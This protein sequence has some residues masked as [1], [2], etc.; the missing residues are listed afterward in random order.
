MVRRIGNLKSVLT[1]ARKRNLELQETLDE[2]AVWLSEHKHELDESPASLEELAG[3]E[4]DVESKYKSVFDGSPDITCIHDGSGHI[5]EVNAAACELLGYSREQLFQMSIFDFLPPQS[6]DAVPQYLEQLDLAGVCRFDTTYTT[7]DGM[8]ISVDVTCTRIQWDGSP[9][10]LSSARDI[11][12]IKRQ[13]QLLEQD[14]S[15]LDILLNNSCDIFYFKD[16]QSRFIRVNEVFANRFGAKDPSELLGK[17]DFDLFAD[18]HASQVREDETRIMETGQAINQEEKET[19]PDGRETW[20]SS[21]KSPLYD[22][23]GKICGIFGIS[24][25]ITQRKEA[26]M[27]L[28]SLNECLL[29][30][31]PDPTANI[32]HLVK[33]CGETLRGHRAFYSRI[34]GDALHCADHWNQEQGSTALPITDGYICHD[35]FVQNRDEVLV[36]RNLQETPYA[37]SDPRVAADGLAT[38]IGR[39]VKRSGKPIGVVCVVFQR[40]VAPSEVDSNLID[41]AALA[42]G[43]EEDRRSAQV[44]LEKAR[45]EAIAA[46]QAK[47]EFLA[48]MSHEI[49]TPMNG[50]I[51]MAELALDT[52]L[53]AE[54]R[55]YLEM[56]RLSADSLLCI[57]NDILDFSKIEAKKLEIEDLDFEL[58]DSIYDMLSTLALRAHQKDLELACHVFSDVPDAVVGDARR[59]RQIIVNLVGNAIKFTESG[60]VVVSV[61]LESQT[62][63]GVG[64]HFS[65]RDTGIGIPPEKQELIFEAFSQ[66]DGSTTRQYGGT[67]LGLTISMQLVKMMGGRMWLESEPGKGSTFHFTTHFR[68]QK[69]P[70]KVQSVNED[71]LK[72]L[73]VLVVDDNA[74]NRRILEEMLGNWRMKPTV[75]NG[76]ESALASLVDMAEHGDEYKLILL[77][78]QMPQMDGFML[79]DRIRHTKGLEDT[80]IMMLSSSDQSSDVA[81]CKELGIPVYLV[82]PV[83]QSELLDA[84]I[85]TVGPEQ[86]RQQEPV[87]EAAP[88][89]EQSE[90]AAQPLRI[91]VAEDNTVN[92]KLVV[93]M[94]ERRG[95]ATTVVGNGREAIDALDKDAFDVVL[96]DVQMP[97]IDGLEASELIRGKEKTAGGHVPIIAMTAHAM[98]GDKERCLAAGMDGYVSKPIQMEELINAVESCTHTQ[99]SEEEKVEVCE[100]EISIDSIM[101]TTGGDRDFLKEIVATFLVEVDALMFEADRALLAGDM[102]ALERAAHS[103]KGSISN[104][105]CK[106]AVELARTLES[107]GRNCD[108][109][110]VD[111]AFSA[112]AG[113]IERLKPMFAALCTDEA[114]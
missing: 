38:Y 96:M 64:L 91:L 100:P 50:I 71:G 86:P 26:E 29:S 65:V 93:R 58:R 56:V 43:V 60:E 3:S 75:T 83:R 111:E 24:R 45:E 46:S 70:R 67:G 77:D 95:H 42:I 87:F 20:V 106:K 22:R 39:V 81:R 4:L 40:D 21:T 1:A 84:I 11:T 41:I 33:L 104:F 73:N 92:Q 109:R 49:R 68:T 14:R 66:A 53:T 48:N 32:H 82:K 55:E 17:T 18:E 7:A 110:H 12:N 30:F 69:E 25:D 108:L 31:G 85:K 59:L 63:D 23:D 57:I 27:R 102:N 107:A 35:V 113:E 62:E 80:N 8:P 74:T 105:G 88:V 28:Q 97:E 79:A 6:Q 78:A 52:E 61:E 19:W 76:G 54:Q 114:A 9:A 37:A 98:K 10:I 15:T 44:L 47:S 51:G 13:M 101:D 34:D 16:T 89:E 94:L 99:P 5:I 90:N 2:L 36:V 72:D 112:L 103:V